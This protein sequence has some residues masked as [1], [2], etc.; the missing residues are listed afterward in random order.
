MHIPTL[1]EQ[2]ILFIGGGNMATA[3]LA[4]L[5][6]N[7]INPNHITVVDKN[8]D[9]LSNLKKIHEINI[10]NQITPDN[11]AEIK[12]DIIILA[13]KPNAM[14]SACRDICDL[15]RDNSNVLIISVAA[16]VNIHKLSSWLPENTNIVRSMPNTPATI[17]LGM[18]ILYHNLTDNS[19]YYKNLS[20]QFFSCVGKTLWVQ[21]EQE[22]NTYMAISGCGPAYVFLFCESLLSAA[23]NLGINHDIAKELI[24]STLIGSCEYY[25]N[26][27]KLPDVLRREV[28]SPNGTTEA[29]VNILDPKNSIEVYTQALQAA[30]YKA[31]IIEDNI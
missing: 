15:V 18:T 31:K 8:Q 2:N 11:R 3:I 29:A 10:F 27:D 7:N 1:S 17:G 28:T 5:I 24:T 16:G 25:K 21:Q 12:P 20:E 9:K 13:V 6:K 14:E 26:S 23:K 19:E 4:G 30:V 22:I